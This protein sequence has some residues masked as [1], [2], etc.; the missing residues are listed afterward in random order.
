MDFQDP[1][2]IEKRTVSEFKSM[3]E[4]VR[5]LL[6]ENERCRNDDKWLL[7]KVLELQDVNDACLIL[8]K[9][10]DRDPRSF[11][12]FQKYQGLASD[13]RKAMDTADSSG[14]GSWIPT[15]FSAQLIDQYRLDLKV[16]S[17]LPQLEM[18]TSPYAIPV[19][20]NTPTSYFVSE[21]TADD[22]SSGPTGD[23]TTRKTTLTA[24]K[25]FAHTQLS[26]E[27]DEDSIIPMLPLIRT[28]FAR[29]LAD[30]LEDALINGDTASPHMD[31]DTTS[32]TSR[33]KAFLGLRAIAVDQS[34][35]TALTTFNGETLGNL[36]ASM[37]KYGV[38]PRDLM[39]V[40]GP[41]GYQ[42]LTL[43]KDSS[44]NQLVTTIDKFGPQATA[45]TGTLAKYVGI[46]I[47]V[48]EFMRED[49]NANGIYDATQT[50][51]G[52]LVVFKPGFIIGNR[53]KITLKTWENI[54]TDQ[55]V[56]VATSRHDFQDAHDKTTER[57]V[58]LGRDLALTS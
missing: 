7:L 12:L 39:M 45:V 13:L 11:R 43:L 21:S 36:R 14:G 51:T 57:I 3:K 38:N 58:E 26:T 18:P 24:K 55:V 47:I 46:D 4:T 37:G 42:R 25:F 22:P 27:L 53:R 34:Y 33:R 52:I 10:H 8:S 49:L 6:S 56:V 54:R 2:T 28:K 20:T 44:G 17:A 50:D 29:S 9:V 19:S 16:A 48:S 23:L 5:D 30:A 35:T 41:K 40:T 1:A 32:A 15:G 31:S